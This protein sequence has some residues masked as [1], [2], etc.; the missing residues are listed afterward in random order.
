MK[1]LLTAAILLLVLH[2]IAAIVG[3]GWLGASGRL[4]EQ[5]LRS[6]VNMFE[7]T[8]EEQQKQ[9]TDAAALA[10]KTRAMAEQAARLEAVADGPR[11]LEDRLDADVQADALAMHRLNR[12][13]V[14]TSD[15]RQQITRAKQVIAEQKAELEEQR[16]AFNQFVEQ[17]TQAFQDEDFRQTVQM[18]EQLKADQVKQMF[19]QLFATGQ[20]EQVVTYLAAMQLRK[21]GKVLQEFQGDDEIA[22]ATELLELLRQRGVYPLPN[23]FGADALVQKDEN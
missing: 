4:S 1:S 17:R 20:T 2:L 13:Q 21:A 19:Q 22:Q 14:E 8:V 12:L 7:L 16:Q 9:Q 23:A 15:L 11:T 6:V 10:E 5:R 3:V 18:Y